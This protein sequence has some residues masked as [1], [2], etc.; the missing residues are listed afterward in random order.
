MNADVSFSAI[1][2]LIDQNIDRNLKIE[3][4]TLLA[5]KNSHPLA[6]AFGNESLTDDDKAFIID[7]HKTFKAIFLGGDIDS[8]HLK[9]EECEQWFAN[10]NVGDQLSDI[11]LKIAR[12]DVRMEGVP[13]DD[14]IKHWSRSQEQIPAPENFLRAMLLKNQPPADGDDRKPL[15]YEAVEHNHLSLVKTLIE[16]DVDLSRSLPID[17]SDA[18]H[19]NWTPLHLA[20]EKNHIDAAKLIH[21]ANNELATRKIPGGGWEKLLYP[22]TAFKWNGYTP[23]DIAK[24]KGHKEL[25]NILKN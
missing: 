17:H 18:Q 15:I 12:L 1:N 10:S 11:V 13:I 19:R 22:W 9:I 21:D 3:L 16:K 20:A 8:K 6:Q 25:V 5:I 24:N 2:W 14:L 23:I 7:H 4:I